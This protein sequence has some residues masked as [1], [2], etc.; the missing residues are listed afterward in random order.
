MSIDSGTGPTL[1]QA[2]PW[3]QD[4]QAVD[5]ILDA[6][7]RNSVSEGLPPFTAETRASLRQELRAILD[8]QSTVP[9]E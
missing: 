9:R 1:R 2:I 6:T 5:L 3:L 4:D 7:E 8:A